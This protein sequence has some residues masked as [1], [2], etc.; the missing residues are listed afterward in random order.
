MLCSWMLQELENM[1]GKS[2]SN[3]LPLHRQSWEKES[4][5]RMTSSGEDDD[6]RL[7]RSTDPL[8][9]ASYTFPVQTL[10]DIIRCCGR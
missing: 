4:P 3:L 7:T 1:S 2:T 5:E 6:L 8:L 10:V 9:P